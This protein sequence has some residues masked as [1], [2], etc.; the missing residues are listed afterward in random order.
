MIIIIVLQKVVFE[1]IESELLFSFMLPNEKVL[2]R[3]SISFFFDFILFLLLEKALFSLKIIFEFITHARFFSDNFISVSI[4][5]DI[6]C[7]VARKKFIAIFYSIWTIIIWLVRNLSRLKYSTSFHSRF[8]NSLR[9][10]CI[11]IQFSLN[12]I[13]LIT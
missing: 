12:G 2:F 4:S 9:F 11:S 3:C 5:L 8:I 6:A 13:H 10:T 7:E 1:F